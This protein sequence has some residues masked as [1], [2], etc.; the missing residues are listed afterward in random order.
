MQFETKQKKRPS[1]TASEECRKT[2]NIHAKTAD[3]DH[4]SM[5]QINYPTPE[6]IS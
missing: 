3:P 5:A 6:L 1:L 2:F 4:L